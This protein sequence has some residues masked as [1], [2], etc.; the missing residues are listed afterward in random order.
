MREHLYQGFSRDFHWFIQHLLPINEKIRG[1]EC[2]FPDTVLFSKGKPKVIIKMDREFC[3]Q[4]IK[5]MS[6][7]NL[8][9]I[10]KDF[11]NIVRERKKDFAGPF[12]KLYGTAFTGLARLMK[13]SDALSTLLHN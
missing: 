2:I 10:Y 6:K 7:L 3:L 12:H 13:Q 11:S 5:Q 9:S 4:A 1:C 8:Q